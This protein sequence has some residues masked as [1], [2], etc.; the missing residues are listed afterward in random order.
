ML[1]AIAWNCLERRKEKLGKCLGQ[2]ERRG[3]AL[4]YM[5]FP[6]HPRKPVLD[7]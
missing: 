3:I 7:R 5:D 4:I 2:P 1:E 6:T